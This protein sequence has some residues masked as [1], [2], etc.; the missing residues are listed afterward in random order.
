MLERSLDAGETWQIVQTIACGGSWTIGQE[1]MD[2]IGTSD[3]Y[4][5]GTYTDSDQTTA[6]RYYRTRVVTYNSGSV[7]FVTQRLSLIATE[8]T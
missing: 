7:P 1:N 6:T 3:L 8:N 5:S 4:G 2:R